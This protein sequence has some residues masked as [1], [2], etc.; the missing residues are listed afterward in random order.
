MLVDAVSLPDELCALSSI[1]LE[2]REEFSPTE[3]PEL[4]GA[5]GALPLLAASTATTT[6]ANAKRAATGIC[7]P[8]LFT[9]IT[10]IIL[11]GSRSDIQ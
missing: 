10:P 11:F 4:V 1:L 7:H 2:R 9:F 3:I 6:I 5:L 8:F